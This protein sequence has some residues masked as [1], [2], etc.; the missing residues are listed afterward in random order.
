MGLALVDLSPSTAIKPKSEVWLEPITS[1]GL[2]HVDI[3]P[4]T[5]IKPKFEFGLK[6]GLLWTLVSELELILTV[7]PEKAS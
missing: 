5:A 6:V 1:M 7:R 3:S 2:A 4:S